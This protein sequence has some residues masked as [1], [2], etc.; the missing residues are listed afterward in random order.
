MVFRTRKISR[1]LATVTDLYDGNRESLSRELERQGEI[2][3]NGLAVQGLGRSSA[4]VTELQRVYRDGVRRHEKLML[5]SLERVL[6][7]NRFVPRQGEV[8]HFVI[9]SWNV[10]GPWPLSSITR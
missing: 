1:L 4:L 7:A 2:T 10:Y 9:L 8:K 3:T 5:E 6:R